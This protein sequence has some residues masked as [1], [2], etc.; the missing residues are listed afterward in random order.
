MKLY[1]IKINGRHFQCVYA[2]DERRAREKA[3]SLSAHLL[4]HDL[5]VRC[6]NAYAF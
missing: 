1:Q 4:I 6:L 2:R 5:S 3:A